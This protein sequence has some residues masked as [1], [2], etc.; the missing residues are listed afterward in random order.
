M[1]VAPCKKMIIAF[2]PH[3]GLVIM[4]CRGD[5]PPEL[6]NEDEGC[7]LCGAGIGILQ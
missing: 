6:G 2:C 3:V 7:T 5:E 1:I 4:C